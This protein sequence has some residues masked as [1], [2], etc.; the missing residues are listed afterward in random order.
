MKSVS[1]QRRILCFVCVCMSM[2][3]AYRFAYILRRLIHV[4]ASW[5]IGYCRRHWDFNRGI[6]PLI[7]FVSI[8]YSLA[9]RCHDNQSYCDYYFGFIWVW[10]HEQGVTND[11]YHKKKHHILMSFCWRR[12]SD[13]FS[14][15]SFRFVL[16]PFGAKTLNENKWTIKTFVFIF[17]IHNSHINVI[18]RILTIASF[19]SNH[20]RIVTN[21]ITSHFHGCGMRLFLSSIHMMEYN[22][23]V[24]NA[25]HWRICETSTFCCYT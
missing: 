14:D 23:R 2:H 18:H 15:S 10:N 11:S 4:D 3:R 21:S 24:T 16:F 6:F 7:L 8:F 1:I 25:M 20:K 12:I 9:D 13:G 17:T 22:E 5:K 19:L